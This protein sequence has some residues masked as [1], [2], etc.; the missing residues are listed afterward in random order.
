MC[1]V[2]RFTLNRILVAHNNTK[3][4]KR[5]T[6]NQKGAKSEGRAYDDNRNVRACYPCKYKPPP[7][8]NFWDRGNSRRVEMVARKQ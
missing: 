1:D 4:K 6:H 8:Q 2:E 7:S 5:E 3:V